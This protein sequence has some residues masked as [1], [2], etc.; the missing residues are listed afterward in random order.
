MASMLNDRHLVINAVDLAAA[1]ALPGAGLLHYSDPLCSSS[2]R[3]MRRFQWKRFA[4]RGNLP[5]LFPGNDMATLASRLEAAVQPHD[6]LSHPFYQ[7]WSMGQLTRADLEGYAAQYL[8]QVESLPSLLTIARG[9]APET[10]DRNLEEEKGH[11][12]LW[13]RF[14]AAVGARP[15]PQQVETLQSR[16]ELRA[17]CSEGYVEALAALWAYE[18]QTARVSRTKRLGLTERY[19]VSEVAFFTLH[20]QLDVHH[21][22]DLIAELERRCGASEDLTRR[23]CDAAK[24]SAQ[25]QWHFLDGAEKRR[26]VAP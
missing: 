9:A 21:A 18:M 4:G 1:P 14:A 16:E 25:A 2:F 12:E 20:E 22:A 19:G 10:I 23:A 26:A 24:R 13:S 5:R 17:L 15:E 8:H 3:S 11:A 6:L 7:A